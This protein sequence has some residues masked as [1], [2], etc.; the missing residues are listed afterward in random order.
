LRFYQEF[1][2]QKGS[3]RP[4]RLGAALAWGGWQRF[5]YWL[6][7]AAGPNL[8]VA[9]RLGLLERLVEAAPSDPHYPAA[10]TNRSR[11]LARVLA[12][13]IDRADDA[14]ESFARSLRWQEQLAEEYP[15]N[16]ATSPS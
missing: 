14:E 1:L 9:S 13:G 2:Q 5:R 12:L 8:P 16:V 7:D 6:G 15:E 10:L 4:C 11:D 3:D